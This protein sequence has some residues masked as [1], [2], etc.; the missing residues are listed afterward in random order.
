MRFGTHCLSPPDIV[1]PSFKAGSGYTDGYTAVAS[2]TC[3]IFS[4]YFPFPF[5]QKAAEEPLESISKGSRVQ[6]PDVERQG[7]GGH[8]RL[9]Q[10]Q[11]DR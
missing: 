5:F 11:N 4:C 9:K 7:V 10:K 2:A 6:D 3:F 8:R 1:S